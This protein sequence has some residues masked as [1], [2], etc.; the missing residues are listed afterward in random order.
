[1]FYKN[2]YIELGKLFYLIAS[3]DGKVSDIEKETLQRYIQTNWK[4]FEDSK[5][6]FGT[7]NAHLIDFSFEYQDDLIVAAYDFESF[8][9]FYR[10][11]KESFTPL[12]IQKIMFTSVAIAESY[13]G[14][15]E[16]EKEIVGQLNELFN[17]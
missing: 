5:D 4:H 11:N 7:D 1:M 14:E 13:R 9:I 16:K 17:N 6:R 12:I 2:L 10:L 8:E 3:V 15:N